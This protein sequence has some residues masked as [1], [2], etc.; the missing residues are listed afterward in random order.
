MLEYE[1]E[2]SIFFVYWVI[3]AIQAVQ[4]ASISENNSC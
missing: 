2:L 1:K 4:N 3:K